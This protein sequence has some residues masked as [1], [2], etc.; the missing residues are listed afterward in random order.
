MPDEGDLLTVDTWRLLLVPG[1]LMILSCPVYGWSLWQL[2]RDPNDLAHS[3]GS[4]PVQVLNTRGGR[5]LLAA[6][7]I[8]V[9]GVSVG[10]FEVAG[11]RVAVFFT[12]PL[13]VAAIV[14]AYWQSWFWLSRG[15]SSLS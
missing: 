10:V 6:N 7:L 4:G 8:F 12:M 13:L 14:G 11:V 5:G 2:V 1:V 15:R 9:T 3:A